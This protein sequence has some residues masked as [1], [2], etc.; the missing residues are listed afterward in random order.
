MSTVVSNMAKAS[1]ITLHDTMHS[2]LVMKKGQKF[3]GRPEAFCIRAG[4]E[5]LAYKKCSIPVSLLMEWEN[6]EMILI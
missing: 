3:I 1:P 6:S 2:G 4:S 5:Y